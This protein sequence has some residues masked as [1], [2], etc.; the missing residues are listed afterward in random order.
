VRE[1]R[2]AQQVIRQLGDQDAAPRP[3]KMLRE[4]LFRK[5]EANLPRDR[6]PDAL[7]GAGIEE[8]LRRQ[9]A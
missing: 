2:E 9:D 5:K 1:L 3:R 7:D 8:N 6:R 4:R